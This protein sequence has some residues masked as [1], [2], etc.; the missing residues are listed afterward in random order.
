MGRWSHLDSDEERLPDGMIRVGYDADTQVYTYRDSD[1]SYWEGAPGC[2]HGRLQRVSTA[3]PLPSIT[4][5]DDDIEGE[6]PP[7]M[8]YDDESDS[9]DGDDET[10]V[11]TDDG[12]S[13]RS[14]EKDA[15][16]EPTKARLHRRTTPRP[17]SHSRPSKNLPSLSGEL[18]GRDKHSNNN[19]NDNNNN[20]VIQPRLSWDAGVDDVASTVYSEK[21]SVSGH[22]AQAPLRRAGTLSRLAGLV[23][24]SRRAVLGRAATTRTKPAPAMAA[25]PGTSRRRRSD[26]GGGGQGKLRAAKT[27]DEILGQRA[28]SPFP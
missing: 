6:E 3:A 21:K 9:D 4:T 7:Y 23:S 13:K 22:E 18:T 2:R 26:G 24:R 19:N 25:E 12:Y 5:D 15:L 11:G 1:G 17:D 27:F 14:Q 8:L 10:W 28:N 16:A 20:N